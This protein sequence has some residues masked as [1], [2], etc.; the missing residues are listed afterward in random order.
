M[1][2]M[3]HSTLSLYNT[4]HQQHLVN[5]EKDNIQPHGHFVALGP[6]EGIE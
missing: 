4:R 5:R 3:G 1:L 2:Q 6:A